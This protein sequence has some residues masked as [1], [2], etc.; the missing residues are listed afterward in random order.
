M[1][2]KCEDKCDGVQVASEKF[3]TKRMEREGAVYKC[4]GLYGMGG[5]GKSTLCKAMQSYFQG[6]FGGRVCR[7]ELGSTE[8]K[9]RLKRIKHVVVSLTGYD[10]SISDEEEVL[11]SLTYLGSYFF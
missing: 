8:T 3:K 7:V 11:N 4:L 1:R 6:E 10:K 2:D 9:A 5:V